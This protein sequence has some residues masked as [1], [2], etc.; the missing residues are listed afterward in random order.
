MVFRATRAVHPWYIVF[1]RTFTKSHL[2]RA[3]PELDR[4]SDDQCRRFV[5]S[6]RGKWGRRVGG[7]AVL[8]LCGAVTAGAVLGCIWLVSWASEDKVFRGPSMSPWVWGTITCLF[9]LMVAL[10]FFVG[11]F[12]RDRLLHRRLKYVLRVRGVCACG[13]SLVGLPVGMDSIVTCP[14]CGT[15]CETDPSLGD[16]EVDAQ[17]RA[18]FRPIEA[19]VRP[20]RF[21]TP[22]RVQRMKR[23][24]ITLL[25]GAPLLLGIGWGGWMF[26][27]A[28]QAAA[29]RAA[30]PNA[31]GIIDHVVR[32]Q[33]GQSLNARN[34]YDLFVPLMLE[35][36]KI[37][38][39]F[40]ARTPKTDA[41]YMPHQWIDFEAMY[42]PP[43]EDMGERWQ[44]EYERGRA[45]ALSVFEDYKASP[46]F[47]ML[48]D[49]AARPLAVRYFLLDQDQPGYAVT[50][51]ELS[52]VRQ[53]GR[54]NAA[55]M[56]VAQ[57]KGDLQEWL[58]AYESNLALV[59]ATRS[60]ASAMEAQVGMAVFSTT[61][62]SAQ[63]LLRTH[64]SND[65]LSAMAAAAARQP[66]P[67]L[68]HTIEGERLLAV[69]SLAWVFGDSSHVRFG[70]FSTKVWGEFGVS[71][72]GPLPCT[73]GTF[74]QIVQQ[75]QRLADEATE[76]AQ[77]YPVEWI[78]K[79]AIGAWVEREG[80]GGIRALN[81]N[82]QRVVSRDWAHRLD[83]IGL[84]TLIALERYR[85]AHGEYPEALERLVP[86]YLPALP[87]DPWAD[88][89][90]R[91]KRIDPA[92]DAR[93]RYFLLYS[94]GAGVDNGGVEL[95]RRTNAREV[96]EKTDKG[97][98]YD[99][100]LNDE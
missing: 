74:Q 32:S 9:M 60:Q 27:L 79:P 68:T 57:E 42:S 46:I 89:P 92:T 72:R 50:L 91:Y 87:V 62:G 76:R 30:K 66:Y 88:A 80:W 38:A 35:Q 31:E 69:D 41:Y 54:M 15:P 97:A 28:R 83:D 90:L 1:V 21:F 100:I 36:D 34:A 18:R 65:T 58:R 11:L 20:P 78:D 29:A 70:R 25:I 24:A 82:L 52:L 84:R 95:T 13:Y 94:V 37:N 8:L 67:P 43:P 63:R 6:A 40:D 48:D 45:Y 39:A 61:V 99:Y 59:R 4:Y 12:V 23:G 44:S 7:G 56:A 86:E 96:L 55:R 33:A 64:P 49:M 81:P 5:R 51:P 14:E 19:P 77:Q 17:G 85:N 2:W 73:L 71:T 53:L 10:P 47:D 26:F 75:I 3:F 98:V 22:V 93:G 16:L